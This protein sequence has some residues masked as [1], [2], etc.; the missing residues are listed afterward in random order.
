MHVPADTHQMSAPTVQVAPVPRVPLLLVIGPP[1]VGKSSVAREVSELLAGARIAFA[2]ADR[3]DFGINGL[4]H[5]DPLL[6][7]NELL[8]ARVA[9]GAQRLVVA[10]RV[11]SALELTRFRVAMGWTDIKVCRLRAEPDALLARIG[12]GEESFQRLHLQTLALEI[13]PRLERQAPEDILLTTDDAPPRAVAMRAY[14]QWTML[15]APFARDAV[16]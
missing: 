10:W 12:A 15:D 3:D 2:Y 6:G 9:A 16:A 4:L 13:A 14:R 11:E 5:E 7:L 8:H 1:A